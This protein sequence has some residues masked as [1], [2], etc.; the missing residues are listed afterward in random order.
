MLWHCQ[1]VAPDV[2]SDMKAINSST[3]SSSASIRREALTGARPTAPAA[4]RDVPGALAV[5]DWI[6]S[7]D[8]FSAPSALATMTCEPGLQRDAIQPN[9]P[10]RGDGEGRAVA[11]GDAPPLFVAALAASATSDRTSTWLR[12]TTISASSTRRRS[13][14]RRP[15]EI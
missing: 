12:R 4:D 2:A 3:A 9:H 7:V 11:G 5:R 10:D 1:L 15:A 13:S 8:P 6:V 14:P